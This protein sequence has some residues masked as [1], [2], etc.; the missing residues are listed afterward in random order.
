MTVTLPYFDGCPNWWVADEHLAAVG[1]ELGFDID[2]RMVDTQ[3]EAERV[4]FRGSPTVVV[5]VH[6][7]FATGDERVGL[8]CAST[9]PATV[10]PAPPRWSSSARQWREAV[11]RN[12]R[13]RAHHRG[14]RHATVRGRRTT[15]LWLRRRLLVPPPGLSLFRWGWPRGHRRRA[16]G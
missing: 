1:D 13:R 15:L 4:R 12:G 10:S 16:L 3:E 11:V 5:N 7:P 9:R 14:S 8:S 2:R 6:D